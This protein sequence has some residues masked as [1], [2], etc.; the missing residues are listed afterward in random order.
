MNQEL[1]SHSTL[2]VTIKLFTPNLI[3]KSFKHHLTLASLGTINIQILILSD[4]PYM[5]F[6]GIELL[7]TQ[8]FEFFKTAVAWFDWSLKSKFFLKANKK[9]NTIQKSTKAYRVVLKF[10]LDNLKISLIPLLLHNNKFATGLKK[11]SELFNS[12]FLQ[13]NL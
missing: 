2:T 13:N 5:N 10:F 8:K 12:Y 6:F 7:Q 3:F 11:K 4:N 1:S 9:V